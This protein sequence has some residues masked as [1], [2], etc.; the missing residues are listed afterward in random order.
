MGD[1][2]P[3]VFFGYPSKPSARVET[4]KAGIEKLSSRHSLVPVTWEEL[5][6]AGRY[7]I[8]P[9]LKA[10]ADSDVAAFDVTTINFNVLFEL[11]YAIGTNRRLWLLRDPSISKRD[12]E[13][14][15]FLTTLGYSPYLNSDDIESEF[16]KQMP[17][18]AER[19]VYES[20][21]KNSLGD[22][23]PSAVFYLKALYETDAE[24][25]IH[26]RVREEARGGAKVVVADPQEASLQTLSWY[27][28]QINAASTVIAHITENERDGSS[29]HNA[30]CA[31]VAGLAEGMAKP[32]LMLAS[33]DYWSPLDY[34]D[35]V[36][37][38][39][40]ASGAYSAVGEWLNSHAGLLRKVQD[41]ATAKARALSSDLR[42]LGLGEYVAENEADALGEYFVRT[43]S[44]T[45]L[46]ESRQSIFVGSKGTGKTANMQ[47]AAEELRADRRNLVVVVKPSAYEL[48]S[49][50]R[51][52]SR[53]RELG[54]QGY[55]I[56]SLWKF[57]MYTEVAQ[58]VYRPMRDS[59]G[60][61][62]RDRHGQFETFVQEH[63]DLILD[64]FAV[65]L[66]AAVSRILEATS[67]ESTIGGSRAAISE[68]LHSQFLGQLVTQ[69]RAVISRYRRLAIFVDN[70]DKAWT[71][72]ASMDELGEFTL[73]LLSAMGGIQAELTK[74][75]E[76]RATPIVS[77][78]VFLRADIFEQVKG[79]AREP[80]KLSVARLS[81]DDDAQL[82]RVIEERYEAA[83]QSSDGNF[84]QRV[85]CAT[86]DGLS[87]KDFVAAHILHRPRDLVYLC[88]AALA[89]AVNRGHARIEQEDWGEAARTY[90]QFAFEAMRVEVGYSTDIDEF[91]Y[92][93]YGGS[94][95]FDS[96]GMRATLAKIG[97]GS[98]RFDLMVERLF[99]LSCLGVVTDRGTT[100]I[101]G[102]A[103]NSMLLRHLREQ[104]ARREVVELEMHP[105]FRAH[106]EAA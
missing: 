27:A 49:V 56:E 1:R 5:R 28:E 36:E 24:R 12:W 100:Y 59:P 99:V 93:L 58:A 26:K 90:S 103:D 82:L 102:D 85:S 14:I 96:E 83:V 57:L 63:E 87:T 91:L 23:A 74:P 9:I 37:R 72:N 29:L 53:F 71:R 7:L 20:S 55:L 106:L 3:V 62:E 10:I 30:R 47:E 92:A 21:I 105:A 95:R 89:T 81:W 2:P 18:L 67:A 77:L 32:L 45:Q 48:Q 33:A 60:W 80:D 94:A 98:D 51:L 40:T 70:L 31:F 68:Q 17:H 88:R 15:A 86:V 44:Y 43:A 16:F 69:L 73:G 78:A 22:E 39:A 101:R 84:W 4:L 65:R 41:R 19:T 6:T 75:S 61:S 79:V 52:V 54:E 76:P 42:R 25:R 13:A 50:V 35:L 66:E 8:D 64:D 11:G 38:Y 46:L 104:L 34:R 97:I